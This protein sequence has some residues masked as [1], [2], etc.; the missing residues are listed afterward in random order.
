MFTDQYL[1]Q[2]WGDIG[3]NNWSSTD[4][5]PKSLIMSD[6]G[7]WENIWDTNSLLPCTFTIQASTSNPRPSGGQTTTLSVNCA[8]GECGDAKYTWSGEGIAN[9]SGSA[10]EISAPKVS[11]SY[12]YSVKTTRDGCSSKVATTS[13][14]I[15]D[16]LPV[17]LV[18]FTA[19]KSEKAALLSWSTTA[20]VNSN[21]FE[22]EHSTDAKNWEMLGNVQSNGETSN[23]LSKYSFTDI[24]PANGENLYRLK[25]IDNDD[26]Y[27]YSRI[28]SVIFESETLAMAYPNPAIDKLTI[29]TGDWNKVDKVQILNLSGSVIYESGNKAGPEINVSDLIPGSYILRVVNT[30]GIQKTQKFVKRG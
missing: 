5:K 19:V 11:G 12:V 7:Y 20:E 13:L 9:K 26:T 27:A 10:I 3:G 22:I 17:T 18:N 25:M 15:G 8:G 21:R 1:F 23:T 4:N 28:V 14:S 16:P 2:Q 6:D 30:S 24:Q 29:T